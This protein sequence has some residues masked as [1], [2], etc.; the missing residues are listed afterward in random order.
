M[1]VFYTSFQ[2]IQTALDA[3]RA[4]GLTSTVV[5]GGPEA[6][7]DPENVLRCYPSV[8]FCLTGEADLS[9]RRFADG[10]A[11][12]GDVYGIP[13]FGVRRWSQAAT[14]RPGCISDLRALPTPDH[15]LLQEGYAKGIYWRA[16]NRGLQPYSSLLEAA[17]TAA[18]SASRW[19]VGQGFAMPP[20]C[21]ARSNS[22]SPW[23]SATCISSMIFWSSI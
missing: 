14:Q 12:N 19:R 15:R 11:R 1:P 3:I 8:R 7:A 20:V 22:C 23:E 13:G 9:L 21:T 5:L 6:T 18:S 10:I 2:S 16:G 17:R 4:R